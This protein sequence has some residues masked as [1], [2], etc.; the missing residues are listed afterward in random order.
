[1]AYTEYETKR[2][3]VRI[4]LKECKGWDYNF[5]KW[6][7]GVYN[8]YKG[9]KILH[10]IQHTAFDVTIIFEYKVEVKHNSSTN[11]R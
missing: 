7:K 11:G 9:C 6:F 1:M 5:G 4:Q 8:K 2:D 3:W 10:I